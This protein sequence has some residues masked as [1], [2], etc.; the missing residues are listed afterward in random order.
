[1]EAGNR[2][3]LRSARV[4]HGDSSD[5]LY[6]TYGNR[7]AS[8]N[9]PE[10]ASLPLSPSSH[11]PSLVS[12]LLQVAI[13]PPPPNNPPPTTTDVEGSLLQTFRTEIAKITKKNQSSNECS[14][15]DADITTKANF[16]KSAPETLPE[17]VPSTGAVHAVESVRLSASKLN[18][19]IFTS[20]LALQAVTSICSTVTTLSSQLGQD[21]MSTTAQPSQSSSSPSNAS[22]DRRNEILLQ[23]CEDFR[24]S[25]DRISSLLGLEDS[26]EEALEKFEDHSYTTAIER[27]IQCLRATLTAFEMLA[28][29]LRRIED[30][31]SGDKSVLPAWL[32]ISPV[33]PPSLIFQETTNRTK[34]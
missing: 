3:R 13:E 4:F 20:K 10:P 17:T 21:V 19:E 23:A 29:Q 12:P 8:Y 31:K 25:A 24:G 32:V 14:A 6:S 34:S 16:E 30:S 18:P 7:W 27:G 2:L 5:A 28:N 1:M 15:S 11:E 26:A 33:F 22:H 9:G